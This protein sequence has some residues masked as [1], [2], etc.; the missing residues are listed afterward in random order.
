MKINWIYI[1]AVVL[2]AVVLFLFGFTNYRNNH[3][4]V[5]TVDIKFERGNNL[6]MTYEM[7]NKLL[8][9]NGESVKNQA[10][11]L[12]NLNDLEKQ[13]LSHP[14][15]ENSTTYITVDGQLKVSVKQRT[16]IG[17]IN[18]NND[19]YYIDR[20][21]QFMP[22]S[23]NYSARVPIVTGVSVAEDTADLFQLLSFVASDAFFQKQ[24][25]SVRK[26]L[27]GDFILRSRIG[28]HKIDFGSIDD[29]EAKF[30]KLKAFYSYAM[31]D[32]TIEKYKRLS[33]KYNDQVVA[34]KK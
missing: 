15:V 9:Q 32:E 3:Q 20:K 27:N 11:S 19:S 10:K 25:V 33:L 18:T 6:F 21:G 30:K 24:I 23:S 8:I 34:T 31:Q 29:M 1:K 5:A 12:I 2:I 13:V 22:L 28:I 4:K 17:R 14:M 26:M 16:P 7:V